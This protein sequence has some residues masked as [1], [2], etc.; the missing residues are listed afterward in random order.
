MSDTFIFREIKGDLFSAPE[1]FALAHC[2][3]VTMTMAAGIA[4]LFK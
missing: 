1:E 3:T 2:V 4:R